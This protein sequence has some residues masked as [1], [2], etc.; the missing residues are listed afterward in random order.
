[1]A[2]VRVQNL[3][4]YK[5]VVPR[6]LNL[7]L[8]AGQVKRVEVIDVDRTFNDPRIQDL[9]AKHQ[10]GLSMIQDDTPDTGATLPFYTTAQLPSAADNPGMMLYNTSSLIVLYSDGTSWLAVE[11]LPSYNSAPAPASL[12]AGY[13]I[14]EKDTQSLLYNGGSAWMRTTANGISSRASHQ[15]PAA[16]TVPVGTLLFDSD[17]EQLKLS[18]GTSWQLTNNV[19]DYGLI[20]NLPAVADVGFGAL[21]YTDRESTLWVRVGAGWRPTTGVLRYY[22]TFGDLPTTTTWGND[23]QGAVAY[24][25]DDRT[26]VVWD[27]KYWRYPVQMPD[28][29]T[30]DLPAAANYSDG[31]MILNGDH[32]QPLICWAGSWEGAQ[33][34]SR[35]YAAGSRPANTDVPEGTCIWNT[36]SNKANWNI[37]GSWVDASGVVDP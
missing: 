9:V 14:W 13:L 27:G 7:R 35:P 37:G 19:Q 23:E 28:Y 16:N 36:T 29:K 15:F 10:L 11:T 30:S 22:A 3:T 20:S 2:T 34:T 24:I 17:N 31:H 8:L 12:P 33:A 21:A 26:I 25:N 32:I 18:D 6:P 4:S 5:L 1:M